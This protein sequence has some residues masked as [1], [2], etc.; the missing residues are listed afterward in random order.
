MPA[1]RRRPDDPAV[2]R[3]RLTWGIAT[4]QIDVVQQA[5]THLP[6][7][8]SNPAHVHRIKAWLASRR[9]DDETERRELQLLLEADPADLPAMD[10]LI[11]LADQAGQPA[12]AEGLRR[13]KADIER[14]QARYEKLHERNQPIRD[15]AEMA[16]LAEARPRVRGPSVSS[17]S[18][19]LTTP[20]A[21]SCGETFRGSVPRGSGTASG[22]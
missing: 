2:W 5:L 1:S 19:S 14:L 17:P 16:R 3:S 9:G 18:R 22:P 15:A 12:Q 4:N 13:Q 10:R 21:R 6:A 8:N 7:E 20:T 11:R